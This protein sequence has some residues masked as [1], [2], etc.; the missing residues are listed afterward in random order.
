MGR[1]PLRYSALRFSFRFSLLAASRCRTHFLGPAMTFPGNDS[2][3]FDDP[4]IGTILEIVATEA[5]VDPAALRLD[6]RTEDV[7]LTSLDLTL[8]VFE[9]EKRFDIEIATLPEPAPGE[10]LT[11]GLLVRHV[12]QAIDTRHAPAAAA[13][14]GA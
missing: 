2:S 7:G 11:V 9:I 4:R 12:L 1:S 8:A 5:H 14:A 10:P 3:P 13:A 6:A